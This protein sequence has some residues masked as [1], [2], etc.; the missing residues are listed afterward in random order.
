[1]TNEAN[2]LAAAL[3]LS[4]KCAMQVI[5]WE[6]SSYPNGERSS[7]TTGRDPTQRYRLA[8]GAELG[9][10][11]PIGREAFSTDWAMMTQFRPSGV[12]VSLSGIVSSSSTRTIPVR[13]TR[14]SSNNYLHNALAAQSKGSSK[15]V[16]IGDSGASCHMTNEASKMYCVRLP[17][18]DQRQVPT[19]D[20]TRLRVECVGNIGV[21]PFV[22]YRPNHWTTESR[23]WAVQ[24]FSRQLTTAPP[25]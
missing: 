4:S 3:W 11:S 10:H 9:H 25:R 8:W 13:V 6:Q 23:D 7:W 5:A 1:M 22:S 21:V 14:P 24:S 15:D 17:V 18:P 16:W 19:S 12:S 20:E 2:V